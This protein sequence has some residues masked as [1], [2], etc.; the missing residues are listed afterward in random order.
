MV[1]PSTSHFSIGLGRFPSEN[2]IV[3]PGMSCMYYIRF[4]PDSLA[5]YDD[6]IKVFTYLCLLDFFFLLHIE[7]SFL[8]IEI[9]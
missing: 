2:G 9:F 8:Y 5:D 1:P 4:S 6:V 3:A 7:V